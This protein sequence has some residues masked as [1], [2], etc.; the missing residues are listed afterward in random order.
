MEINPRLLVAVK[1]D[2]FVV[3]LYVQ[4]I[5]DVESLSIDRLWNLIF[6][7]VVK[8]GV[9]NA[10]NISAFLSLCSNLER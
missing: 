10:A 4:V 8:L 3:Q 9:S 6:K 7:L 1:D 5:L 2:I